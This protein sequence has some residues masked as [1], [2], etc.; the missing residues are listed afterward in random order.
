MDLAQTPPLEP[1]T[2]SAKPIHIDGEDDIQIKTQ[3]G[4]VK[5]KAESSTFQ[6]MIARKRAKRDAIHLRIDAYS[7][8]IGR[9]QAERTRLVEKI[10][11]LLDAE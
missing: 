6:S 3:N 1:N 2:Q 11:E 8:E 5:F 7:E 10:A 4:F 9:I